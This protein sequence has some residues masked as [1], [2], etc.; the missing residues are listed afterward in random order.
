MY[1]NNLNTYQ[2]LH[3]IL[4]RIKNLVV[5]MRKANNGY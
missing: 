3:Y 5:I 1:N 4:P 2:G